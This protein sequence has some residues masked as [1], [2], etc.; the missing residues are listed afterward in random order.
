MQNFNELNISAEIMRSITELGYTAPTP[1]Q[2]ETLPLLLG[3][4]TDAAELDAMQARQ[5]RHVVA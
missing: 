5:N 2:A 4:D 3:A 1:I